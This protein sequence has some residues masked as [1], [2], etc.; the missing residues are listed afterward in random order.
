VALGLERQARK[1]PDVGLV[2]D[3]Q[4]AGSQFHR[5]ILLRIT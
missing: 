4:D 1:A 2:F 3:Q 5:P